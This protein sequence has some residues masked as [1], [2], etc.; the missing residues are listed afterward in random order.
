MR[1]EAWVCLKLD[2]ASSGSPYQPRVHGVFVRI[3]EITSSIA[4]YS[5]AVGTIHHR[6]D[7]DFTI[8]ISHYMPFLPSPMR[9]EE[10]LRG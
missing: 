5:L 1:T 7:G 9:V 10:T 3:A 2:E 6:G 8:Y 4:L